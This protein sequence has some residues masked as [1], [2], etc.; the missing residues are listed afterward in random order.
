M[1]THRA[2]SSLWLLLATGLLAVGCVT[3]PSSPGPDESASQRAALHRAQSCDDLEALLKQDAL[4]K[5]NAQIDA[6]IASYGAIGDG[7]GVGFGGPGVAMPGGAADPT[8]V[9]APTPPV[10]NS[11]EDSAAGGES[12]APTHSDT[13]TQVAGVDEADIVKTDGNHIYILHDQSFYTLTAWPASS[14]AVG[15]SL[16][17]E[18]SPIEMFVAG[19]KAVVYSSVNGA[20]IYEKAGVEPRPGYYDYRIDIGI[21]LPGGAG[22]PTSTP[23]SGPAQDDAP[24]PPEGSDPPPNAGDAGAPPP[25]PGDADPPPDA[26]DRP[27]EPPPDGDSEPTPADGAPSPDEPVTDAAPPP[28]VYAPLTKLTVLSLAGGAPSVARELYFE[29]GYASARRAG[30]DVRTVLTGGAHGPALSYWPTDL[31]AFPETAEA[32]TA[33]FEQLRAENTAIIEGSSLSAWLPYRFEKEGETV[34]EL[35]ASCA[36]FYIPEAGTTSYGLTQIES[37]DLDDLDEAPAST[38]IIGATD[39]VYSSHDAL[40]VAARGWQQPTAPSAVN[41]STD[42]THLHK[43]DLVADPSQPR[44]VASGSVPGHILNQFS[45]DEHNGK[46]RVSTTAM[47]PGTE[48]WT[49]R[50]GV[51]VLEAQGTELAR[52]GAITDLAPGEQIRSTRFIGDRGYVV[53]FLQVD[54]LFVLDLSDPASPSVAGELKIPGFSE[55]MHPLDD[56]HLLAIGRDGDESG[57]VTGLSLQIFDVTNPSAPALLHKESLDG[58]Y[59]FSEAEY[60]HKAFTYYDERDVLAFPV[61]SYDRETGAVAS[62]LELFNVD[63]AGGFSHLGAVDHSGFFSAT[64]GCYYYGGAD[65]KRGLFIEDYVYSISYGGVLVNALDDLATPVASLPLPAPTSWGY[66]CDGNVTEPAPG[67]PVPTPGPRGEE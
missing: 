54:P 10:A 15:S 31:T 32:W 26:D 63:I 40:Y 38:S 42:V 45:L 49:T 20:S 12:D 55:Y 27:A 4:A 37:I 8:G 22:A 11:P 48:R 66:G 23:G 35:G 13:N 39:T 47:V 18:G 17:I 2:H 25:N 58:D 57:R 3:E 56:G 43:F 51:F 52:I 24:T 44:Y 67:E 64:S 19:D 7:R 59:A 14:L 53:T 6:M 34:T 62:A 1:R 28:D 50:N 30:E 65:V 5:M 36:D 61:V 33:A 16:A 21:A 60:N 9:P 46:L 41:A 29:G